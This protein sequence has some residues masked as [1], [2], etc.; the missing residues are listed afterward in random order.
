[1]EKRK[2]EV[3]KELEEKFEEEKKRLGFKSSFKEIDEI[4]FIKDYVLNSGFVSET[5]S[6]Q[7][8]SRIIDTFGNWN[9]YLHSLILPNP[10][11]MINMNEAKML[12]DEDKKSIGK[13]M[14]Q[15]IAVMSTNTLVGLTKEKKV[16]A[17]FI[18]DSVKFWNSTY[19]P[20]IVELMTKINE[21]WKK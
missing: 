6:R 3:L 8:C 21:G 5:F 2:E 11:H 15:A 1:M 10:H 9:N 19:K 17:E 7:L 13:L 4:F 18:D 16:E 20:K 12:N 14:S